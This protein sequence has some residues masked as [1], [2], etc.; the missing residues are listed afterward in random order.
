MIL[1]N[2]MNS[3]GQVNFS[4]IVLQ[5]HFG[6]ARWGDF[7]NDGHLD[8]G[9]SDGNISVNQGSGS[10]PPSP[11]FSLGSGS[12]VWHDF[13]HD[14]MVDFFRLGAVYTELSLGDSTPLPIFQSSDFNENDSFSIH[15]FDRNGEIDLLFGCKVYYSYSNYSY[16]PKVGFIFPVVHR[17]QNC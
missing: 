11:N 6:Q 5:S 9:S 15:D 17:H 16:F 2:T 10:Y 13:N 7:N 12:F 14:G 4:S 8:L 1:Q 3:V